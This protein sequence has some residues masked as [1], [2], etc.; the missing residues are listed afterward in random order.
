MRI[1][2]KKIRDK[3]EGELREKLLHR[4]VK[5]ILAIFIVGE[6]PVIE[7]FV[8]LKKIFAHNIGVQVLEQRF[9][10][11][12]SQD[13]FKKAL[14]LCVQSANISGIVVQLPL[15]SH[16][17]TEIILN[18]IPPTKDVDVLSVLGLKNFEQGT[19][20]ILPP[21]VGAVREIFRETNVELVGK[22]ALVIGRGRLVGMPVAVWLRAQGALVEVVD[23][24]SG[25]LSEYTHEA[26]I[27]VSGA[28]VPGLIHS[29]ILT[30]GVVLIDAGSSEDAGRI[31]GDITP[32]CEHVAQFITPV[33]GG[34]GPITV[35]VLFQNLVRLSEESH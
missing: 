16:L 29:E 10:A 7:G 2:G 25:N 26:E 28:G 23:R 31:V 32:E 15:P 21:V 4:H 33:P 35:A 24:S 17:D 9:S 5:P 30:P 8:N 12:V 34:V 19:S 18:T 27:V 1:N 20:P 11:G 14:D 22:K 13:E 6:N 3:I